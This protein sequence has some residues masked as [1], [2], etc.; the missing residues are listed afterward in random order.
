LSYTNQFKKI[1]FIYDSFLN[2]L[3]FYSTRIVN[4]I[5]EPLLNFEIYRKHEAWR[6]NRAVKLSCY[7]LI[8]TNQ[9]KNWISSNIK[10]KKGLYKSWNESS[11]YWNYSDDH[12][13]RMVAMVRISVAYQIFSS[14]AW[15]SLARMSM[16]KRLKYFCDWLFSIFSLRIMHEKWSIFR[17]KKF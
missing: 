11:H 10:G 9:L 3:D 14:Q 5:L 15:Y 17:T 4:E 12:W 6:R 7:N 16:M 2:C 13:Q 1:Q 8:Y